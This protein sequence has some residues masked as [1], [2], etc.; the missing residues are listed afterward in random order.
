MKAISL[1]SKK[2]PA[3]TYTYD[4]NGAKYKSVFSIDKTTEAKLKET[5]RSQFNIS[6]RFTMEVTHPSKTN[7]GHISVRETKSE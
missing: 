7:Y 5:M 4:L 3:G 6:G 1:F 2:I